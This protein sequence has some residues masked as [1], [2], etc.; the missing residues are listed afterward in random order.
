MQPCT[1]PLITLHWNWGMGRG[2]HHQLSL[3]LAC[4]VFLTVLESQGNCEGSLDSSWE[5]CTWFPRRLVWGIC[6]AD[7]LTT[8]HHREQNPCFVHISVSPTF[9]WHLFSV[10]GFQVTVSHCVSIGCCEPWQVLGWSLLVFFWWL[11]QFSGAWVSFIECHLARFVWH[12]S[13]D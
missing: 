6:I 12:V 11:G 3:S 1:E 5:P 10:L 2:C 7:E 8:P 4:F 9:L 13:L